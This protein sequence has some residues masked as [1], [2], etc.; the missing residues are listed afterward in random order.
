MGLVTNERGLLKQYKN[1]MEKELTNQPI[2]PKKSL[3]QRG[4]ELLK[5]DE[6]TPQPDFQR[7]ESKGDGY[8]IRCS[9]SISFNIKSPYC[10]KCYKSWKKYRN[11]EYE[12]KHC[13][14]CSK[15]H[16]TSFEKPICYS[17]FKS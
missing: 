5:D 12:E 8:C 7:T 17:C 14:Q 13:H 10:T 2:V 4:M 15:S 9:D 16:K 11:F 1:Y 6:P 3:L